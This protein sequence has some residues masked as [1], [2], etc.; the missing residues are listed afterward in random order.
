VVRPDAPLPI[1]VAPT[2]AEA[3]KVLALPISF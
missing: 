1:L 2:T 3:A